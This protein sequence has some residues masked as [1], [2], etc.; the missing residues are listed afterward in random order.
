MNN[1]ADSNWRNGLRAVGTERADC[2][3]TT[4]RLT[5]TR[6]NYREGSSSSSRAIAESRWPVQPRGLH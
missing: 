3:A 2:P 5:W 4:A 6:G 1:I